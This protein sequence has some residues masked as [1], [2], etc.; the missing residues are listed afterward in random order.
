MDVTQPH[1]TLG[2][3]V[4]PFA[5]IGGALALKGS[6][7]AD[8]RAKALAMG[9]Q[10]QANLKMQK[11]LE[12]IADLSGHI[13][14]LT[15]AGDMGEN[16]CIAMGLSHDVVYHPASVQTEGEDTEQAAKAILAHGTDLV[17]FAGGDGTARNICSVLESRVPA[18]GVPA[19]CK[20]H[21]GVYAVTPSAA[22]EVIRQMVTGQLVSVTDAEVRDIDENAFREGKVLAKHF[23]ELQVPHSL[24]YV[25]AVKM[26]GKES[27]ELVLDDI[28]A[29]V[30]EL[31]DEADDCYWVMGSGSTVAHIM[32]TLGLDN[33]LLGVDVVYQG[34]VIAADAT[35]NTL[36][37]LTAGKPV[38]LVITVIGGQGH[39]FGRGNQQLSP[40]F[41]QRVGKANMLVVAS[42]QKLQKLDGRPLR[43]DTGDSELDKQLSGSFAVI[44]GYRDQVLYPAI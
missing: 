29:H 39:I 17:V 33:T 13:K 2:V 27:E 25:Q 19:G 10:P 20:I 35:A 28:A 9:A 43:L 1:F 26:G 40:A 18:L 41:L 11:A 6:D 30:T 22:G 4:N 38:R 15:A 8:I 34:E 12:V 36:L 14:V 31:M 32:D 16:L 23:G 3:I 37:A 24:T 44:T 42:K 7:G 5:G 21:S